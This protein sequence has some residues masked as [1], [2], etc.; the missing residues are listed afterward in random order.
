MDGSLPFRSGA[1][2]LFGSWPPRE[3]PS[4]DRF[5]ARGEPSSLIVGQSQALPP[6]LSFEDAV[7][8]TEVL[9]DRVLL[10][11]DPTG[12]GRH[13]DLPRLEHCRHLWVAMN[14]TPDR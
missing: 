11:R 9:D 4:P 3:G 10:A 5:T 13:E 2:R 7:L 14:L 1:E 8:F 12:H 6:E